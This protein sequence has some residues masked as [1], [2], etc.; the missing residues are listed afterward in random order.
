MGMEGFKMKKKVLVGMSGGVDSAVA[1]ALLIRGGFDVTGV[2]LKLWDGDAEGGCC[3][4]ADTEDA[5]SV[6]QRLDI[7]FYVLNFKELF[8]ETVVDPFVSSYM[9]GE[10]P[11]PCLACNDS[12]KFSGMLLKAK[13]LGMDYI[14]TGHYA[15]LQKD[16]DTGRHLL[17][18]A[19]D[20]GK[21]QSYVLYN[22]SQEQLAA[23]LFPLGGMEKPDVRKLARELGFS[24]SDKPDSQDI[25]FVGNGHYADFIKDYANVEPAPGN[26]TDPEGRILGR[27]RGLIH[28]TVGQRKHL[29]VSFGKRMVVIAKSAKENTIIVGEECDA[30]K[31]EFWARK[32]NWIR[33][34]IP[35][36]IFRAKVR[37]RYHGQEAD[38]SI[39]TFPEGKA[40][41]VFDTQQHALAPGQAAVFY[42]G[43]IVLGGGILQEG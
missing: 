8:R 10:T 34:E 7:P 28:Y 13:A 5:R 31:Q 21:D 4:L 20:A 9:V 14:A 18:K 15:R 6:A 3:S 22:L 12:I 26:F 25:C 40:R 43:D 42:E 32:T 38:A 23:T 33:W 1:A 35:P 41:I 11:N 29:G 19:A 2:T 24:V 16:P 27:H 37:T 30:L 36:A 39:E 17:M